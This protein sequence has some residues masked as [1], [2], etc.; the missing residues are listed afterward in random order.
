MTSWV[1]R[2]VYSGPR[3]GTTSHTVSFTA[4]TAGNF[5][6][7]VV[8]GSVTS[9]TPTGWASVQS[10]VQNAGI[11]VFSKIASNGESSFSTTHNSSN[12]PILVVIYEFPADSSVVG[13]AG[14]GTGYGAGAQTGPAC[15]GLPS[16]QY[17]RFAAEC[18]N[19]N[20]P[21]YTASMAWTLPSV[22]DYDA[23]VAK[24][25]SL[26]TDGIALSI[27]LNEGSS[28]ASFTPS[29]NRT[30]SGIVSGEGVSWAIE[31]PVRLDNTCEGTDSTAVT[32]AN[33]AP[34]NWS[35]VTKTGTG[36]TLNFSTTHAHGTSSSSMLLHLATVAS[37]CYT[38]WSGQPT[39][40]DA[41]VRFYMYMTAA[42]SA[43]T[44][45]VAFLGSGSVRG[46]LIFSSANGLDHLTIVNA[47]GTEIAT[48]TEVIPLNQWVRIEMSITSISAGTGTML[49]SVH[50]GA[51]LESDTIDTGGDL[52]SIGANVGGN[53]DEVRIGAST[54][55]T[56][57]SAWDLWIDEV[58]YSDQENP[59]GMGSLDATV[60]TA[61]T[62]AGTSAIPNG[63]FGVASGPNYGGSASALSNGM[64]SWT[65]PSYASG[66]DN[67]Q[68]A[69]WA[70]S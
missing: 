16:T 9:S 49:G 30:F 48:T 11:Y 29:W 32:N 51:N 2:S 24:D 23:Y 57:V 66:T 64:G 5:L 68:Y 8:A 60:T 13:T 70:V 40:V 35:T 46:S 4:A 3:N 34:D 10:A 53:I 28:G 14:T 26:G 37:T 38:A 52:M 43:Q 15:T 22:E 20:D 31:L 12:Y 45:L 18:R 17:V 54:S 61:A 50:S 27:A 69:T 67:D 19:L 33:T 39:T 6:I 58:A 7:A 41:F 62:V 21:S 63:F 65:N 59:G 47:A 36:T 44:T 55:T 25:T 56:Q 42:P 1:N